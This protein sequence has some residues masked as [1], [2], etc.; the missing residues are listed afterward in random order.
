[1]AGKSITAPAVEGNPTYSTRYGIT[2]AEDAALDMLNS[3]GLRLNFLEEV[4]EVIH[5]DGDGF[6]LEGYS[7][8]G[9]AAILKD[10]CHDVD[11]ARDYYVGND[12]TPGK[13]DDGLEAR[14]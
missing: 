2:T 7:S 3:A 11:A 5:H 4:F 12:P 13:I 1:M 10:I 9:L 14:S 6:T 8:Q